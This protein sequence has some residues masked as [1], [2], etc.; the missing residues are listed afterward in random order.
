MPAP[1]TDVLNR[2]RLHGSDSEVP[3]SGEARE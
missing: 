2:H 1:D 3:H